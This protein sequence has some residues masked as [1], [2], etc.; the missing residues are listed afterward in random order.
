[1]A[2]FNATLYGTNKM[3][4]SLQT[5]TYAP[6]EVWGFRL[7][8][9]FNYSVAIYPNIPLQGNNGIKTNTFAT[10]DYGLQNFE[11]AKPKVVEYE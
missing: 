8:P 6:H 2:G 3:V 9:F 4:L 7:N 5:Q 11:L 10:S 1:L